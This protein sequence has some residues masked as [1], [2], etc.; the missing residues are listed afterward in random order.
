MKIFLGTIL[1]LLS[2]PVVGQDFRT[3][4]PAL[5]TELRTINEEAKNDLSAFK[6]GVSADF[7]ISAPKLDELLNML[8]PAEVVLAL[9]IADVV[10][11]PVDRV[12]ES[13]QVNKDKGWGYIAKEPGIKPGS[14]EFHAL[15]GKDKKSNPGNKG[16][17]KGK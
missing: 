11:I 17:G 2:L 4:D 7:S 3:G 12:A 1:L 10:N 6:D 5:E 13:Y 14:P 15:K 9:R 16:G 8:Q